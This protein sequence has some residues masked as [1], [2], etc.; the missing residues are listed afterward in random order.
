MRISNFESRIGQNLSALL[1][2]RASRGGENGCQLMGF[3]QQSIQFRWLSIAQFLQEFEPI[4]RLIRFFFNGPYFGDEIGV[5]L[6]LAGGAIICPDG[7]CA[8]YQL[9]GDDFRWS[10]SMK[11]FQPINDAYGE[12]PSSLL[13]CSGIHDKY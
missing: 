4:N 7:R 12:L 13:K 5:R 11:F 10:G 6:C 2:C 3:V 1:F 9:F 8:S